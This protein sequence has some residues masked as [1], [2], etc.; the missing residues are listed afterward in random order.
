MGLA[1]PELTVILSMAFFVLSGK[2]H[3]AILRSWGKKSGLLN[4]HQLTT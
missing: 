1:H 2:K 4:R 3:R